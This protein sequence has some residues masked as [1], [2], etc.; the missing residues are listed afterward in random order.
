M[1][2]FYCPNRKND[3]TPVISDLQV[4]AYAEA[5]I[6]DYDP[7]L[8]RNPG[9]LDVLHFVRYYLN[10]VVDVQDI[11]NTVPGMEINGITV[12]KDSVVRVRDDEGITAVD[13]PAGVIII[14]KMV[15]GRGDGYEMFTI[16]FGIIYTTGCF[17]GSGI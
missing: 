2:E 16:R 8:L 5:Q 11:K 17:K 6:G 13:Y 7:E 12:L 15:M 3:G 14:D 9:K 10:A 4:M 1:L